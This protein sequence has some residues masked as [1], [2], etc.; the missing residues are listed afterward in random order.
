MNE[1]KDNKDPL[2][3]RT[4]SQY[5]GVTMAYKYNYQIKKT[6][7]RSKLAKSVDTYKTNFSDD[8]NFVGYPFF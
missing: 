4:N 7:D 6:K 2:T 3:N 5:N 8:P 1:R